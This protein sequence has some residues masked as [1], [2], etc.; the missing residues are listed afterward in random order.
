MFSLDELVNLFKLISRAQVSG[1]EVEVVYELKLKL[2]NLAESM[3]KKQE[4]PEKKM[5]LVD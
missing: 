5:A 4:S 3:A 2:K 1:Q